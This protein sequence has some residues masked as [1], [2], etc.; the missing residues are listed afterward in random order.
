MGGKDGKDDD[1]SFSRLGFRDIGRTDIRL[2]AG[3]G[4]DRIELAGRSGGKPR[5][6]HLRIE[7]ERGLAV[8]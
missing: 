2:G 6:G 1:T 5:Y 7:L 4:L 3:A 8:R